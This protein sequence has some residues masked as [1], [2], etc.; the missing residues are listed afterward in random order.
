NGEITLWEING[1]KE[2]GVCKGH[3]GPVIAL[4]FSREGK[5][6]LSG[7]EDKT[8][9]RWSVADAGERS[10]F[11]GFP[12]PVRAVAFAPDGKSVA[13]SGSDAIRVYETGSRKELAVFKRDHSGGVN[14]LAFQDGRFL[15]AGYGHGH[16]RWWDLNDKKETGEIFAHPYGITSM[17]LAAGGKRLLTAGNDGTLRLIDTD[18]RKFAGATPSPR[19]AFVTI[20]PQGNLIATSD[21]W[22]QIQCY[23]AATGKPA[24]RVQ[25]AANGITQ[26][27]FN[28]DGTLLSAL[29]NDTASCWTTDALQ[30]K[31]AWRAGERD[32]TALALSA[33]G[34]K[35]AIALK[36]GTVALRDPLGG[37]L[38]GT[39]SGLGPPF[40]SMIFAPDGSTL[41]AGDEKGNLVSW[42]VESGNRNNTAAHKGP[43]RHL[44]IDFEA[45]QLASASDDRSVKLWDADKL[46]RLDLLGQNREVTG[47][48]FAP[49]GRALAVATRQK[50]FLHRI[51][52]GEELRS[53][54]LPGPVDDVA[55]APDGRHLATANANGTVW[56]LYLPASFH[57]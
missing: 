33:A 1:G 52:T 26:L 5:N 19:V 6:L 15:L 37:R 53:W 48:S 23:D 8:A 32:V 43:I 50:L 34:D 24:G 2:R 3:G 17:T 21:G 31:V 38:L 41:F 51:P 22:K 27:R 44:A 28:N 47:L 7:S 55:Y 10:K 16:L 29:G 20:S 42:H 14:A 4:A 49:H 54:D 45:K 36:N 56:I 25:T 57:K 46:E 18:A 39:F 9:R 12:H 35:V 13:L 30:E 40:L 11:E